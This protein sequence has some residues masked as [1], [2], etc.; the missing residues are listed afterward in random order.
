M[1]YANWMG[2]G[3]CIKD[4]IE[5]NKYEFNHGKPGHGCYCM[6]SNA[7]TWSHSDE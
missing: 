3:I 7:G 5:T 2:V 4:V 1:S 6:S